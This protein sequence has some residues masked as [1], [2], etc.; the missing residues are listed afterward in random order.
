MPSF[1]YP[2]TA[3]EKRRLEPSDTDISATPSPMPS[4]PLE[5][6]TKHVIEKL[7]MEKKMVEVRLQTITKEKM[8]LTEKLQEAE[9]EKKR[10]RNQLRASEGA[11]T[12]LERKIETEKYRLK[13]IVSLNQQLIEKLN[14]LEMEKAA[15]VQHQ[16]PTDFT[17]FYGT[18]F[19]PQA[20]L[21][22][23]NDYLQKQLS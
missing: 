14:A 8:A 6:T 4:D 11:K 3:T 1:P 20:R 9:S 10:L 16:L 18:V 22:V 23:P 17:Q 13:A 5:Q 21:P 15:L 2:W 19:R 7:A 12:R